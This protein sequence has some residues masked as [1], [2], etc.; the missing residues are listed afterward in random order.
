MQRHILKT[1]PDFFGPVW[2]GLKTFEV[3]KHDRN[4]RVGDWLVLDE[5]SVLHGYTGARYTVEVTYLLDGP[6]PGVETGYCVMAIR[7]AVC[8]CDPPGSGEE[9]CVGSCAAPGAAGGA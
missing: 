9:W 7:P 4:F 1:W 2:H 8:H 5:W 3:R 6:W